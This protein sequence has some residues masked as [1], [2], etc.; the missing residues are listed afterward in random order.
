MGGGGAKMGQYT[1]FWYLSLQQAGKAQASMYIWLGPYTKYGRS[2]RLGPKLRALAPLD[3]SAWAFN[4]L[5]HR[6]AF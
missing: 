3:M 6:G 4:P 1:R 5:P 2:R